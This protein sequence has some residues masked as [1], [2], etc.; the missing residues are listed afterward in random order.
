MI[1]EVSNTAA[2]VDSAFIFIV[3]LSVCL[4]VLITFFMLFFV[5]RYNRRRNPKSENIEGNLWLEIV[6]TVVPTLLVLAMFYAGWTNFAY[7]RN[8]PK[9]AMTVKTLGRNWSW[10]FE[11][12]NGRQSDVLRVPLGKPVELVLTSAD[13]VHSLY[14]P[15]FRIKEDA[16]PGM[17]TRMWFS[18]GELGTYDIYCTE[19]C[20]TGHSHMRTKVIVMDEK[21]F[22]AWY[23]SKEEGGARAKGM[24]LLQDRGCLG[25]HST[26]GTVKIGPTFKGLWGRSVTVLTDG[27]ERELFA[28]EAYIRRAVLQPQAELVKGYPP[29]MPVLPLKSEELDAIITALK[30]LK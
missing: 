11:Y 16:V 23:V 17:K 22:N 30:D 25:C 19:Y 5:I 1:S 13:V 12:K 24:K 3:G 27:R 28:D 8:A 14:I 6:W 29:I 2:K 7:I 26:D 4:L 9:D 10:E 18:A 21:E 20:G 15:A